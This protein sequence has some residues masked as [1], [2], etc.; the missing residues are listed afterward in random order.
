MLVAGAVGVDEFASDVFGD[1]ENIIALVFAFERGATDGVDGFALLVHHVVVFEE[2]LAGVEVLRFDGFL[3]VFDAAGDEA[4]F[5]GHAFSH[6]ET[7]HQG[8]DTFAAEDAH[9]VVFERKEK[10]GGSGVALAASASAQL[11]IDAGGFVALGAENVE[12][13]KRDDFIMFGLAL[14]GEI[15]VDGLPLILRDLENLSFVLEKNHGDVRSRR[16]GCVAGFG[17]GADDSR[18]LIVGH[19]ETILQEVLA[20]HE[21]GIAAELNVG[22][23][24]SHVGSDRNGAPAAGLGNDAG[25]AFVLLGVQDFVRDTG[26]F[27]NVGDGFGFFDG[28]G[29]YENGLAAVVIVLD[30][31]GQAVV[32]L[33]DAVDDSFKFFFFRSVDDVGVF[34]AN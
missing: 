7:E 34:D 17:V 5:D 4:G 28:D 33:Q 22:T 32:F 27:E 8:F 31:V 9:E 1:A 15:V 3:C 18:S 23:S 11:V 6:A 25:F 21:F 13:A 19:R 12:S 30:A 2:V 29:A 10:A 26:L 14:T 20:G 16:G 24:A